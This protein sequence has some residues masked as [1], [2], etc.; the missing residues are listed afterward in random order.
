[1]K[2]I[3]PLISGL[4]LVGTVLPALLF[5]GGKMKVDQINPAMLL[6]TVIWFITTPFWMGR[7]SSNHPN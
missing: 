5:L 6:A 7:H 3:L 1:M 2:K 4:A